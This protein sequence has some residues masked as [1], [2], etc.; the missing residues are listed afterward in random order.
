M[1]GGAVGTVSF[2]VVEFFVQIFVHITFLPVGPFPFRIACVLSGCAEL[3]ELPLH[4]PRSPL[5]SF[6]CC[7]RGR[8]GVQC[9]E[10]EA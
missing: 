10:L 4:L 8:G 7:P 1:D 6:G 2:L 9:Y 3:I 5:V